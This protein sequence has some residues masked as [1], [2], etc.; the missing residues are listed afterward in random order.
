[1]LRHEK[2]LRRGLGAVRGAIMASVLGVSGIQGFNKKGP[3][4]A[5]CCVD[6]PVGQG[7][8]A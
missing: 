6:G 1:L 8:N 3:H 7:K 5:H 2:L 4:R